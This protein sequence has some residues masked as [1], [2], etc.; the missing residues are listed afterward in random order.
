MIRPLDLVLQEVLPPVPGY[1][2]NSI[3]KGSFVEFILLLPCNIEKLPST[4]PMG[5][6]LNKLL[7]GEKSSELHLIRNFIDWAEAWA[8]YAGVV[9]QSDPKRVGS[10]I[11]YFL[12]ISKMSRDLHGTGWLDYDRAFRKKAAESPNLLWGEVDMNLYVS[13]VLSK[14][15]KVSSS[16]TIPSSPGQFSSR[17]TCFNWNFR[18]CSYGDNCRF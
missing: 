11:S 7:K 14:P 8:V 6:Q 2:V 12:L 4:E 18:E 17:G 1:L 15:T 13:T 5:P 3:M 9:C 16:S 10:L